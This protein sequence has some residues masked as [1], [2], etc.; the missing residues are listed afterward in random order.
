PEP[1]QDNARVEA[2]VREKSELL[3][4]QRPTEPPVAGRDRSRPAA[5]PKAPD[6]LKEIKDKAYAEAV[7]AGFARPGEVA[8]RA[9]IDAF[10]EYNQAFAE[11]QA[12]EEGLTVDEVREL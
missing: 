10:I 3:H 2:P 9:M 1:A 6:D 5:E 11:A 12:R 4:P 8:F 7:E